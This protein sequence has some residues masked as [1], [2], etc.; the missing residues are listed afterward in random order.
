MEEAPGAYKAID[1]VVAAAKHVGLAHRVAACALLFA[2]KAD[3]K[4]AHANFYHVRRPNADAFCSP[5]E[6][7]RLA[8]S[9]E[10]RS[11]T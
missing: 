5:E 2:L 3:K 9:F 11:Q 10:I 4:G 6:L 7:D 8:L 1:A